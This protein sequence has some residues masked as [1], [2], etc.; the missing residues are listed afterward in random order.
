MFLS[1]VMEL[2]GCGEASVASAIETSLAEPELGKQHCCGEASV[3]SAIETG[4]PITLSREERCCGEASVASAIETTISIEH[5]DP[6]TDVAG[7]QASRLRLKH[8]NGQNAYPGWQRCGEASVASA[9]ETQ[10][11]GRAA[12]ATAKL[13]GSKRRVCD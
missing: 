5:V 12:D 2:F 8:E 10:S 9:I 13:R 11:W 6:A 3:A 4:G 7:K 1:T